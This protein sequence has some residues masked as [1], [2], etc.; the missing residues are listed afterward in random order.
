MQGFEKLGAFYLGKLF[1][2]EAGRIRDELLLYESKD[3]TIHGV[4]VG[5]TGSWKTG[6]CLSLNE[7]AALVGIPVLAIDPKGDL[8][9][10]MLTFPE[11]KPDDFRPWSIKTKLSAEDLM[12]T[13]M[14]TRPPKSGSHSVGSKRSRFPDEQCP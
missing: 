4:C 3:L 8:G 10:L 13:P 9:N 7:E 12:R 14:P 11:M 5:M 1:D 2:V 6:L